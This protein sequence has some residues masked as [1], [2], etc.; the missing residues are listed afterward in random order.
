MTYEII[1]HTADL[2]LHV[3]A[4]D[5]PELFTTAARGLFDI[6]VTPGSLRAQATLSLKVDGA[7]WPDLLVNW[8]RE[9]LYLWS[10]KG[11]LVHSVHIHDI[12]ADRIAA[13]VT[14]DLYDPARHDI[15]T[16]IKAVTYHQVAVDRTLTGWEAK[17]IF[18]V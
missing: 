14:V 4:A 2:G 10:G 9:L 8:L 7:D 3:M 17:I 1:D 11:L 18:D 16:E 13:D 12:A 5:P 6:M 15:S